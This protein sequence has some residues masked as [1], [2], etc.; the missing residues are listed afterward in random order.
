M[1]ATPKRKNFVTCSN[2]ASCE[3]G[4]NTLPGSAVGTSGKLM[5][6]SGSFVGTDG[7]SIA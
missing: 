3:L 6:S 5:S 1:N 2:S 4:L 7:I